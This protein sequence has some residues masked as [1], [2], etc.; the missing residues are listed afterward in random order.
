MN[1]KACV[2]K[3]QPPYLVKPYTCSVKCVLQKGIHSISLA[4]EV[5]VLSAVQRNMPFA[6]GIK[7]VPI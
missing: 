5:A 6:N 3:I 7:D 4:Y 2:V 1:L